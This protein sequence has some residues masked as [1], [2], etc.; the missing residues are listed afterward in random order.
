MIWIAGI[1]FLLTALGL[2]IG[3][4]LQRRRVLLL[5]GTETSSAAELRSL[6]KAVAAEIGPGSFNQIVEVKGTSRC[7]QP[8]LAE[9]SGLPCV[10]YSMKVTREYEETCWE[11]D[12][13]GDKVSRQKRASEVVAQNTRSCSFEVDDGTGRVQVEPSEAAITAEKVCERFERGEPDSGSLSLPHA[14]L[15]AGSAIIQE[16]QRTVGY[17]YEESLVAVGVSIY[18]VGEATDRPGQVVIRKPAKGGG[19]FLVSV[20]SEEELTRSAT[21]AA[22]WLAIGAVASAVVGAALL[23]VGF[24]R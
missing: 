11:T 12:S 16:G 6:A 14:R 2:L 9:L 21:S 18:V 4:S 15:C 19:N 23:I 8:L 5:R 10:Y 22:T 24:L 7:E 20:K 13:R 3:G 17:R 1:A